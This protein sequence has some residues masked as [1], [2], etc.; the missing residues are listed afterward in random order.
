MG[1]AEGIRIF[2]RIRPAAEDGLSRP[3]FNNSGGG[4]EQGT[5]A[6]EHTFD[7]STVHFHVD[8][9][10]E[11]DVVN[12]TREDYRF[13]FRRAFEPSA[14]QEE[15]FNVV[16]KDCVLAALD[17]YNSTIFAYG[18]TGSGKTYSITGG[19][20]VTRIAASFHGRWRS[21]TTR[22]RGGSGS[23]HGA[24]LCR[25]CR[26]TTTRGRIYSTTAVTRG[27]WRICRR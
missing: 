18:Q 14:T 17:G 8:R 3:P 21:S 4:V 23:V 11:T 6:V 19:A 13:T 25:T 1:K 7:L 9:R 10:L 2:L 12:N 26:Y 27:G 16:A 15:V 5:Y 24:S 22:W 20:E